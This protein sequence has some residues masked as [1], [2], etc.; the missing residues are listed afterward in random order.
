[1]NTRKSLLLSSSLLLGILIVVLLSLL[2]I[3]DSGK[4][5]WLA[6]TPVVE[7]PT[8]TPTD[9]PTFTPTPI[10]PTPTPTPPP[11]LTYLMAHGN[12]QLQEIALTFDDGP[13]PG[14]TDA[15]LPI[16]QRYH[17]L[18]TFF[19]LGVWVQRYPDLA[20]AVVAGGHTIGDHSWAHPDLTRLSNGQITW[21]LTT[22]RDTIEQVTGTQPVIF[23]PPYGAYTR[24]VL[25][26]AASLNLSSILWNVD[27]RD[28]A[29]PGSDAIVNRVLNSTQPG[30]I[31][32]L[33][34]GGGN[35]SQTV[36]AL[37]TIIEQLQARGL[38]FVTIPQML[39]H[40]AASGAARASLSGTPAA[41]SPG[42]PARSA[43]TWRDLITQRN[44]RR[45]RSD[46]QP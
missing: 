14:Y 44:R 24:R 29:R 8:A 18:A 9:M 19:M 7:R 31:I 10:P 13:S 38:V 25:D 36:D 23:R 40:L 32:L 11:P 42:S 3:G 20:R 21:Q 2:V 22:T 28:W 30:S 27:P 1:M 16:L 46:T 33:H 26:I 41:S 6:H 45:A 35:R 37:P 15:I 12:Q 17:I 5:F 39:R 34:D 4:A 43:L